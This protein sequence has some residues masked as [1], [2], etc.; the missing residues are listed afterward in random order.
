MT[1]A[2]L[3][4]VVIAVWIFAGFLWGVAV[5]RRLERSQHPPVAVAA[6]QGGIENVN[7]LS[8]ADTAGDAQVLTITQSSRVYAVAAEDTDGQA[9]IL[10]ADSDG[11]VRAR[12]E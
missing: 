1:H 7:P 5:G 4:I 9:V 12:C 6:D 8:A 2:S 3:R 11:Y 10:R